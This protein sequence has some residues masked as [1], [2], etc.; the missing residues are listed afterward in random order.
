MEELASIDGVIQA[1]ADA[2]ISV[3]DEGLLRGDGA[4]ERIP[5]YGGRPFGL[6]EH[7]DR[8]QRSCSALDLPCQRDKLEYEIDTLLEHADEQGAALRIVLT[9]GGRRILLL[10]AVEDFA[11]TARLLPVTYSTSIVLDGVK[12]ISYAANMTATRKAQSQGFDDA[13]LVTPDE[14]VLEAPTAA[15]FWV[16][17]NDKIHTPSL[18]LGILASITRDKL[19]AEIKAEIDVEEDRF[20]LDDLM[21]AKEAFIVSSTREVQPVS[22]IGD[23]TMEAPGPVTLSARNALKCVIERELAA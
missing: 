6:S 8:L 13:L 16:D 4:F 19:I 2:K 14:I 7:L 18:D 10:E 23:H 5:L 3:V 21:S 11:D 22:Q 17:P 20:P 9:R 1:A 15:I 12:S